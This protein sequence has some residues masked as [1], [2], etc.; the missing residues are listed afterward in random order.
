MTT[1]K[2]AFCCAFILT[3]TALS[4]AA[5]AAAAGRP[6]IA[7][8]CTQNGSMTSSGE[9]FSPD[10]LTAAHRTLPFGTIV[11]VTNM[12][13]GHTV[14][15]RINDRGPFNKGRLIDVS[16][17]AAKLLQFSGLTPVTLD[18]VTSKQ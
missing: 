3:I 2:T 18:V 10:K 5:P 14:V 16:P 1:L 15:V 6:G 4:T 9:R 12:R 7:A 13:N 11:R 17:A 8:I